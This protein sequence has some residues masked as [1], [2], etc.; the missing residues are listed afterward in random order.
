MSKTASNNGLDPNRWFNHVELVVAEK[1]GWETT[2][3]VRNIYKYYAAYKLQLE[4]EEQQKQ[5]QQPAVTA[6]VKSVSKP[7]AKPRAKAASKKI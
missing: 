2:T 6:A 3:Y 4:V 7:A 5:A 1:V